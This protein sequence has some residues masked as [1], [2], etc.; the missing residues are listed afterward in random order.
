MHT[1]DNLHLRYTIRRSKSTQ[2]K[3]DVNTDKY[4]ISFGMVA[5]VTE[6]HIITYAD[7]AGVVGSLGDKTLNEKYPRQLERLRQKVGGLD[8]EGNPVLIR[9]DI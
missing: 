1:A 3:P 6:D 2:Y 4:F 9:Y 7:A 8:P 5:A